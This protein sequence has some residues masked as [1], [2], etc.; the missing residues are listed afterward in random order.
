MYSVEPTEVWKS[1]NF[2]D[3]IFLSIYYGGIFI[4][5]FFFAWV[6]ALFYH[7]IPGEKIGK[8][9]WYGFSI[10]LVGVL[11]GLFTSYILT[12]IA[13][14]VVIYWIVNLLI[15]RIIAGIIIASI[16]KPREIK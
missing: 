1:I 10:W 3:P 14:I 2:Q 9:I 13:E 16:Y 8:G 6:F 12:N 15:E 7:G 11:P 4:L 5:N